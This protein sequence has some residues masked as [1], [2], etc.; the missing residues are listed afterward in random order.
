MNRIC[1]ALAIAFAGLTVFAGP[2]DK[3]WLKG[4]TDKNPLFYKL[5]ETMVFTVTPMG[6]EGEIPAGKYFMKWRRS[7]DDGKKDEGKI[8]FNGEPFVYRTKLEKPGFVRILAEIVDTDG[9]LV[10]RNIFGGGAGAEIDTLK[11]LPE[12]ADFDQFWKR[13]RAKLAKIPVRADLKELP[14]KNDKVRIYGVSVDCAGPRPVTGYLTVPKAVDDGKLF[15]CR[16]VT[17]GYSYN[18]P[19]KAPSGGRID[20]IVF[21]INAHGMKLPSFG[22]D[23]EYYSKLG[24]E[25]NI[26]GNGYGFDKKQNSDPEQA[27]F[28]GMVLRVIR[29]LQYLKTVKG[30]DGKN[31]IASGGSQGGL[32][33]IWAAGCG[34]G[35][36]LAESNITWCCDLGGETLGRNRGSWYIRWVPALGYYDAVNF[37]KRI[38][39]SCRTMIPR[40]G[41]GDYIC[42][43]SGLAILWNNIKGPKK[44]SWMQG[45]DHGNVPPSYKGRDFVR[46]DRW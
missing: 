42:P 29:A 23:S 35:V 32:Q 4:E 30:W 34:E 25:I 12:P 24:K 6:V 39:E 14:S 9:K 5:G 20:E 8:P 40:A 43:P 1:S 45:S 31:L 2:L 28:N 7:G 46:K 33:T 13:Q 3:S 16:L 15:P 10:K 37:A 44:I 18:P 36:T 38:P 11:A 21:N 27:Y 17:H 41:L 19:H 26:N 22:G